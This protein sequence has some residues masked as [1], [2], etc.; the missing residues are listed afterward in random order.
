MMINKMAI[1]RKGFILYLC[2]LA[3]LLSMLSCGNGREAVAKKEQSDDPVQTLSK[4]RGRFGI[5]VDVST[6]KNS[7]TQIWNPYQT[8][9]F[10]VVLFPIG[11]SSIR[12][13][14]NYSS[15][16]DTAVFSKAAKVDGDLDKEFF[17]GLRGVK[18]NSKKTHKLRGTLALYIR[19]MGLDFENPS[20]AEILDDFNVTQEFACYYTSEMAPFTNVWFVDK[21]GLIDKSGSLTADVDWASSTNFLPVSERERKLIVKVNR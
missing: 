14:L 13:N 19:E 9:G 16:N 1:G 5:F 12:Y 7:N 18:K 3:G 10:N 4:Q 20:Q 8:K 17:I 6:F 21:D 11:K 2:L 15:D